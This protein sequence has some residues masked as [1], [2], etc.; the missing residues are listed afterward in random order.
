MASTSLQF[1]IANQNRPRVVLSSPEPAFTTKL[2]FPVQLEFSGAVLPFDVALLDARLEL[3]NGAVASDDLADLGS[4]AFSPLSRLGTSPRIF[5]LDVSVDL[6]TATDAVLVIEVPANITTN[7]LGESNLASKPLRLVLDRRPP[8][9]Q[10]QFQGY[11]KLDTEQYLAG[12]YFYWSEPVTLLKGVDA[13]EA[14]TIA[15]GDEERVSERRNFTVVDDKTWYVELL[16]TDGALLTLSLGVGA[17]RDRAGRE[18]LASSTNRTVDTLR[19]LISISS[20]GPDPT[21][22][23]RVPLLFSVSKPAELT[24][25][26]VSTRLVIVSNASETYEFPVVDFKSLG[27]Y[28][29]EAVVLVQ[30]WQG[31]GV[32]RV[33]VAAD[34]L[35]DE[36]GNGNFAAFVERRLDYLSPVATVTSST[37]NPTNR[38]TLPLTF[39]WNEPVVASGGLER[40]VAR[41]EGGASLEITSLV[42]NPREWT[43]EVS[44]AH[45]QTVIVEVLA[46]ACRD[47][48]GNINERTDEPFS[49]TIDTVAPELKMLPASGEGKPTSNA[50]FLVTFEFSK[51]VVGFTSDDLI[52]RAVGGDGTDTPFPSPASFRVDSLTSDDGM[53]WTA[54]IRVA[55]N[56]SDVDFMVE[57]PAG[58]ARD[59]AGNGNAEMSMLLQYRGKPPIVAVSAEGP[60]T[61]T[62]LITFTF[63]WDE[64][65][66][67]QFTIEDL[68]ATDQTGD[69]MT[70]VLGGLRV[71]IEGLE[72]SANYDLTGR[73]S[74]SV[75]V[76][77]QAVKGPFGTFNDL[78]AMVTVERNPRINGTCSIACANGLC[79][80]DV[81]ACDDGFQ[82]QVDWVRIADCSV[83]SFDRTLLLLV[84]AAVVF[85]FGLYALTAL[86]ALPRTSQLR[87]RQARQL[88]VSMVLAWALLRTVF[89]ILRIYPIFLPWN[90]LD[91]LLLATPSI[92]LF[93]AFAV[94]IEL[95]LS[96]TLTNGSPV[97]EGSSRV[98]LNLVCVLAAAS[99]VVTTASDSFLEAI[100]AQAQRQLV[101]MIGVALEA[102]FVLLLAVFFSLVVLRI[103]VQELEVMTVG[104]RERSDVPL[105]SV[106]F[107]GASGRKQAA[108]E[109]DLDKTYEMLRKRREDAKFGKRFG[110]KA[111]LAAPP[112]PPQAPPPRKQH[113]EG[114]EMQWKHMAMLRRN[115]VAKLLVGAVA[116]AVF[117]ACV[118]LL[119]PMTLIWFMALRWLELL[120]VIFC[121]IIHRRYST[122]RAR[123]Q[124]S[125]EFGRYANLVSH[126]S[127]P[128]EEGAGTKRAL[129]TGNKS[130]PKATKKRV[131]IS[132]PHRLQLLD[133]LESDTDSSL[134]I[135]IS[136]SEDDSDASISGLDRPARMNVGAAGNSTGAHDGPY[137]APVFGPGPGY[138]PYAHAPPPTDYYY[139]NGGGGGGGGYY[140]PYYRGN[141]DGEYYEDGQGQY[142]G[143]GYGYEEE[144]G[145]AYRDGRDSYREGG[146]Q[147]RGR[148]ST[149]DSDASGESR[150]TAMPL[151]NL[152]RG[153]RGRDR[154]YGGTSEDT[155]DTASQSQS[156]PGS[157]TRTHRNTHRN[158]HTH[159]YT[160]TYTKR[161]IHT[162]THIHILT[163]THTHTHRSYTD[164]TRTRATSDSG[165]TEDRGMYLSIRSWPA[166]SLR[167]YSAFHCNTLVELL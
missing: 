8:T 90:V 56:R 150:D 47:M 33:S 163:H 154:R 64:V 21:N 69:A 119:T 61:T 78:S 73:E 48:A 102:F 27:G 160:R 3:A 167:Q 62:T 135:T 37:S 121:I 72:F 23:R 114:R 20:P 32:L 96:K 2:T 51:P 85:L 14:T 151:R 50:D 31:E 131:Q 87:H 60:H 74:V 115:A 155:E 80:G 12:C 25:D 68:V 162:L 79:S 13:I 67:N 39:T 97:T 44:G 84:T 92:A 117:T 106:S 103:P 6:R 66:G 166:T 35:K 94:S 125:K 30:D 140:D 129:Q 108:G 101:L 28:R 55:A 123:E 134:G 16:V 65:I 86:V 156:S 161:N 77:A 138:G 76:K 46:G 41:V 105:K 93:I 122:V 26:M 145:R 17:A 149:A 130:K 70:P 36:A 71:L 144:G 104:T 58:V 45:N 98:V 88:Q 75:G 124:S 118:L 111:P 132:D 1:E 63:V 4:V 110:S 146:G 89:F 11:K 24:R 38:A 148:Y 40:L 10:L 128:T 5:V 157:H 82:H 7:D 127:L 142:D 42:I 34:A 147:G 29:W 113:Q 159:T 137:H 15:T 57:V 43:A 136:G 91:A 109:Y 83:N 107:T 95:S 143:G 49:R 152:R 53:Q 164:G 158:T 22:T 120:F 112:A 99:L 100:D 116:Y 9:A 81:C 165:D 59:A 139:D 153:G 141:Q 18:N 19:P 126:I 52:I 54:R 133:E